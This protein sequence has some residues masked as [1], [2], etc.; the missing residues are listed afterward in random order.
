M[1]STDTILDG[2]VWV[3]TVAQGGM[4]QYATGTVSSGSLMSSSGETNER[5]FTLDITN[6]KQSCEYPISHDIN[7]YPVALL[8]Y[9]QYPCALFCPSAESVE[10]DCK[11][12][13]KPLFIVHDNILG[14]IT[15]YWCIYT[16]VE[17]EMGNLPENANY[18]F[19]TKFTL[20][21]DGENPITE[22]ISSKDTKNIKLG[23]IARAS[24][25]W[26]GNLET[27]DNC[28]SPIGQ[29]IRP[30]HYDKWYFCDSTKYQQYSEW[31]SPRYSQSWINSQSWNSEFIETF[32]DDWNEKAYDAMATKNFKSNGGTVATTNANLDSGFATIDIVNQIQ[33]P[34]F[35]FYIKADTLGI[36]QPIAK[37]LILDARGTTFNTGQKG[38]VYV[39][40]KNVG[41]GRGNFDVSVTCESPITG[42]GLKTF[43]GIYPGDIK[44]A[45][46]KVWGESSIR[47]TKTCTIKVCALTDCVTENVLVTVDPLCACEAGR[48]QCRENN[49]MQCKS[50]CSGWELIEDC[51]SQGKKCTVDSTGQ[52]ICE[53]RDGICAKEGESC[54]FIEC[55][56][57][58]KCVGGILGKTCQ[59]EQPD[60]SWIWIII[61]AVLGLA[62]GYWKLG[63]IGA[64]IGGIIGGIIGLVIFWW[65]GLAWWQQLLLGF[66][67]VGGGALLFYAMI[68]GGGLLALAIVYS[69]VKS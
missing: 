38:L 21:I 20:T 7:A 11:N 45:Y 23:N 13:G 65:M 24:W 40:F 18:E 68:F 43:N 12:Y 46:M 3:M 4:A 32:I 22:T 62:I 53:E 56:G 2:K 42:E 15:S 67:V 66:G 28:P 59:R 37:P 19:E 57:N 50:D 39:K 1:K 36:V 14:T 60:W 31:V 27:G 61:I 17:H 55:C 35:T 34:V 58:L 33:I 51:V 5:G 9:K 26:V 8:G 69:M 16:T 64:V 10:E 54:D 47:Q 6:T 52:L 48:M 49:I 63:V 41:S 30:I 29:N 44:E 25:V